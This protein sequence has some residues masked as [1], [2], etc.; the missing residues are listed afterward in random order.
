MSPKSKR[1]QISSIKTKACQEKKRQMKFNNVKYL[2][3][4]NIVKFN[5][6]KSL[7]EYKKN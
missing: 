1:F 4:F 5:N 7:L 2:T 3:L 6:V